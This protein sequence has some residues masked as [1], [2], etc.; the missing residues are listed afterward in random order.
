MTENDPRRQ[1]RMSPSPKTRAKIASALQ[2]CVRSEE[3]RAKMSAARA[4]Y[5]AGEEGEKRRE[6]VS[7]RNLAYQRRLKMEAAE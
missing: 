7:R 5:Y 6:A 4:A 3:T 2:G 1:R